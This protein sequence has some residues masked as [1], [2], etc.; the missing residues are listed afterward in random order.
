MSAPV[1]IN[2]TPTNVSPDVIVLIIEKS[3]FVNSSIAKVIIISAIIDVHKI[4]Y[5]FPKLQMNEFR[6]RYRSALYCFSRKRKANESY[7]CVF[8]SARRYTYTGCYK[9]AR[10]GNKSNILGCDLNNYWIPV[11]SFW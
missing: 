5:K 4:D 9:R 2:D 11:L 3:R 7:H 10:N 6:A 8:S 1:I